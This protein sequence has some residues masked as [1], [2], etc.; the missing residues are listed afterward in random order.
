M[1]KSSTGAITGSRLINRIAYTLF[2]L[3]ALYFYFFSEDKMQAIAQLGIAL[4]FDPFDPQVPWQKRP[5]Y[6]KIW[7]VAHLSVLLFAFFWEIFA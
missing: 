7:L 1:N 5:L 6:Q 3:S 2:V 4:I